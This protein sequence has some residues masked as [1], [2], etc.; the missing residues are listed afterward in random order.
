LQIK[1][2]KRYDEFN[3]FHSE[4]SLASLLN[5]S[6]KSMEA[7]SRLRYISPLPGGRMR[8]SLLSSLLAMLCI[9]SFASVCQA[10]ARTEDEQAIQKVLADFVAAWNQHD[11]KVLSELFTDDADFVVISAKHLK[12]RDE[13]FKYHN[14]LH[15][16]P[17]KDHQMKAGWQDM[18]FLR[19]DVAL[20]HVKF[21]PGNDKTKRTALATVVL[22]KQDVRWLITGFQNTL[23]YGPPMPEQSPPNSK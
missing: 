21:E 18:R 7:E 10:Q 6:A 15:K 23:L 1:T 22:V 17:F 19:N 5:A 14:E 16:G 20:G 13:I 11:M 12:G 4:L 8:V 2:L 3:A 9:V